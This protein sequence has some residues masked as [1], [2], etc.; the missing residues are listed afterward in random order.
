MKPKA[1]T[2]FDA[3][4]L[5]LETKKN[6]RAIENQRIVYEQ[7]RNIE[8]ATKIAEIVAYHAGFEQIKTAIKNGRSECI[9][10]LTSSYGE[11][12]LHFYEWDDGPSLQVQM[13]ELEHIAQNY[14]KEKGFKAKALIY[15]GCIGTSN[16]YTGFQV[17]VWGWDNPFRMFFAR[18]GI[19]PTMKFV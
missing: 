17:T 19:I 2:I 9:M 14:F 12:G 13:R 1:I 5:F 4:S 8:L 18:V 15:D 3:V 16:S 7:N 10:E 6:Q 11:L